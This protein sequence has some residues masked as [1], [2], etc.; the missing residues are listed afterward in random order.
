MLCYYTKR[1]LLQ[2]FRSVPL[3]ELQSPVKLVFGIQFYTHRLKAQASV[4]QH[5][6][7]CCSIMNCSRHPAS[8]VDY[9]SFKEPWTSTCWNCSR[10]TH[11]VGERLG[12]TLGQFIV[13]CVSWIDNHA[14]FNDDDDDNGDDDYNCVYSH[15]RTHCFLL[16]GYHW[17]YALGGGC[18][19]VSSGK[20]TGQRCRTVRERGC[21]RRSP[22][23]P[24]K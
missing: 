9:C 22:P 23:R 16:T 20:R 4:E 10:R 6:Q 2:A 1:P 14:W 12:T 18:E 5:I 7:L 13:G 19:R 11:R 8:A 15:V 3:V 24:C 21:C 17:S